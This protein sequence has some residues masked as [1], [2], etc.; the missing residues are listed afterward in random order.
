MSTVE[1]FR[2]LA[3]GAVMAMMATLWLYERLT[4]ELA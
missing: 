3:M 4:R 1:L 2:D